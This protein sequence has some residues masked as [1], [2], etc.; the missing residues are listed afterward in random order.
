[1]K[2]TTIVGTRP[3]IIKLSRVITALDRSVNHT[4]IHTNQNTDYELNGI[5]FDELKIRQPD[6]NLSAG[7]DASPIEMIGETIKR[8]ESG[9]KLLKPDAVLILGD[10]NSAFAASYV[11]KR[12]KIPVFHMEAGNRCYDDRVPEEINRRLVDH[13]SDI[14]LPY[15][16][17][18]RE[19][20]LREGLPADRIIKTG[21]PMK[22]VLE[23]YKKQINDSTVCARLNLK[24]RDYFLVSCHREE[25]IDSDKNF[26]K[27][28]TLLVGVAHRYMQKVIVTT[29]PRTRKRIEDKQI[30]T[31]RLP[32]DVEF[33][34]PF[35]F[36]D[37]IHLQQHARCILS[38]SGTLT[39]ESSILGFP[40]LNIRETHERQEGMEEGAVMLSGF[41]VDR[42]FEG[43]A[44]L[45][46]Q[47]RMNPHADYCVHN[48]SEKVVRII[49][50]YTDYINRVVWR[51][52][53]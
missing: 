7:K 25:N 23:F 48:V 4:I 38:D 22:E 36:F 1:M 44:I 41:N 30:S 40:A 50:S 29:H 28:I 37:Y 19:N 10:T 14:N 53:K 6:V 27:F 51:K 3:E 32:P 34:R 18:A 31:N 52:Y 39:E 45:D 46:K 8:L 17:I 16:S 12:L 21:S 24:D 42:I 9:I 47:T 13:A 49:L 5:F 11:A 2:V 43:V 15:S 33:H 35:G 26:E 20:L